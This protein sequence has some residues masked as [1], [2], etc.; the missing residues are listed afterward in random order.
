MSEDNSKPLDP[1]EQLNDMLGIPQQDDA[2]SSNEERGDAVVVMG[3]KEVAT[4]T[5]QEAMDLI[6]R[7]QRLPETKEGVSVTVEELTG[8]IEDVRRKEQV[9]A[10]DTLDLDAAQWLCR[11]TDE[12]YEYARK[13]FMESPMGMDRLDEMDAQCDKMVRYFKETEERLADSHDEA[14]ALSDFHFF[15]DSMRGGHLY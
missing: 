4:V 13:L 12:L 14:A 5:R 6:G 10:M 7:L 2:K 1:F 15:V 3:G 8:M 9:F 11:H